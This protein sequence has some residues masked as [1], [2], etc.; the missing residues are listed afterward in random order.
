MHFI[1]DVLKSIFVAFYWIESSW[2]NENELVFQFL[3]GCV[4]KKDKETEV[5]KHMV[6]IQCLVLLKHNNKE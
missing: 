6:Y 2:R 5:Y 3:L 4:Y 1:H